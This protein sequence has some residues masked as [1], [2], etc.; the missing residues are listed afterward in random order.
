MLLG[1][2]KFVRHAKTLSGF[3]VF[4]GTAED[5]FGSTTG[6]TAKFVNDLYDAIHGPRPPGWQPMFDNGRHKPIPGSQEHIGYPGTYHYLAGAIIEASKSGRTLISD[7]AGL[8]VPGIEEAS[9]ADNARALS[10]LLAIQ[11]TSLVL[12]EIVALTPEALMEF[13][14]KN[15]KHLKTFRIAMLRYAADLNAQIA[16]LDP[17]AIQGK[18]EFFIETRVLPELE[19]LRSLLTQTSRTWGQRLADAVRIG[20]QLIPAAISPSPKSAILGALLANAPDFIATEIAAKSEARSRRQS[21]S[22]YY[23]LQIERALKED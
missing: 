22:L 23:L 20:A 9:I 10:T 17:S 1:L 2:M 18:T 6:V 16:G 21:S 13:R 7:R 4:T 11:C 14:A 19:E 12:P 5:V 15:E 8:P 3:C